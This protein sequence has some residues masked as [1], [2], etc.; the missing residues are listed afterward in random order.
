MVIR[1]VF[2]IRQLQFSFVHY[3]VHGQHV[4]ELLSGGLPYDLGHVH[5][6][7]DVVGVHS[8]EEESLDRVFV[9]L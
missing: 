9:T 5:S 3:V 2:G 6:S 8:Y 1:A 7:F 4:L